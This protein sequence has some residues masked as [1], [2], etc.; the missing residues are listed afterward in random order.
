MKLRNQFLK[1][2]APEG[3]GDGGSNPGSPGTAPPVGDAPPTGSA[4]DPNSPAVRALIEKEIS[5]LK[6]KNDQLI[7]EKRKLTELFGDVDRDTLKS[8]VE[9]LKTDE[10]SRLI[11]EGKVDEV[12]ERRT[13]RMRSSYQTQLDNAKKAAEDLEKQTQALQ[14]KYHNTLIDN[15]VRDAAAKEGVVPSAI[16]DILIRARRNFEIDSDRLVSKDPDTGEIRVGADGKTPYGASDFIQDLKE[17]APHFWPASSSG[18]YS[19]GDTGGA[20]ADLQKILQT[21]GFEAY[22]KARA[23]QNKE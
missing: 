21:K 12:M 16:E 13:E 18:G 14:S 15:A 20:S 2:C 3:E 5:A 9:R 6:E 10:E 22:K 4:L 23:A 7:G 19:P 11:A 8:Y 1:Y 17:K